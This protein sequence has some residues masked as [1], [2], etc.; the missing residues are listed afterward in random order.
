MLGPNGGIFRLDLTLAMAGNCISS[1]AAAVDNVV[2]EFAA[3]GIHCMTLNLQ[4]SLLYFAPGHA[5]LSSVS[6]VDGGTVNY[7][8]GATTSILDARSMASYNDYLVATVNSVTSETFYAV[9]VELQEQGVVAVVGFS[10]NSRSTQLY[11]IRDEFQPLPGTYVLSYPYLNHLIMFVDGITV[12]PGPVS[13][14]KS[15]PTSTSIIFTWSPPQYTDSSFGRLYF[16]PTVYIMFLFDT[17]VLY[18]N[19]CAGIMYA[20]F[21]HLAICTQ[22]LVIES[23]ERYI[24]V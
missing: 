6:L 12:P 8:H 5:N 2:R 20:W 3:T 9:F 19:S 23:I 16:L 21:M 17:I 14:G 10:M 13:N 4:E 22:I 18:L 24:M 7:T 15:L 11:M 1:T